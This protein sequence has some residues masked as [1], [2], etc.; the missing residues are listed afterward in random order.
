MTKSRPYRWIAEPQG[1]EELASALDAQGS[2]CLDSESNSG[3]AYEERLCLLQLNVGDELWLVDLLALAEE[4]AALDPLRSVLESQ[5]HTTILHGGEFDVGCLKRDYDLDLHGVWDTQ[6][7]ASFLGW[8]KTGY[9]AVV[10]RICGVTLPKEHA[11]QDWGRRPIDT[12][13]LQYALNDVFYLPRV[14][15][16][17]RQ[18]VA[19]ADLEEE[20]AIANGTVEESTW[21]GGFSA[22]GFWRVKG[23]RKLAPV[24]IAVL[25]SLYAWRDEEAQ[26]RD[27]PPG[28]VLNDRVLLALSRT[29]VGSP[30]DLRRAG[31][32]GGKLNRWGGELMG[33]IRS[34]RRDPPTLSPPATATRESDPLARERGE[35]LRSWRQ[36]E[37]ERRGVPL[38]V[39]L[40]AAALRHLQQHGA[41]DLSSVPQLG[42][43]RIGL[44]GDRLTELCRL[45]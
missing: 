36:Q 6:Q 18:E 44:Y 12:A 29:T 39:V 30:E 37:A 26:E 28:R 13:P 43:K 2:H 38:Q 34:V 40:P 15:E 14:A 22:D 8:P 20:V 10:E 35:R 45:D 11:H 42:A 1:L 31:I 7:A 17:L 3:F 5:S 16:D 23:A 33:R 25:A 4:S 41:E 32:Q 19:A 21:N 9:G 27:L 24:E